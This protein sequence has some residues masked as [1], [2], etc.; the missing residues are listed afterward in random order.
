MKNSQQRRI[1]SRTIILVMFSLVWVGV[2]VLRLV[3][4]Q[5]IN[6]HEYRAIV[7]KQNQSQIEIIPKRGTIF[8]RNG[9]ILAR[10][11]PN[12]SLSFRFPHG[13]NISSQLDKI[14]KIS[15]ICDLSQGE[16]KKIQ[17]AIE[18]GEKFLYIRRKIDPEKAEKVMSL[19]LNGFNLEDENKRFYPQGKLASHVIG[20]VDVDDNGQSG[21]EYKYNSVLLGYM[22]KRVMFRDANSNYYQDEIIEQ[23]VPGK[24]L[25]LTID[26]TIQYIAEKELAKAVTTHSADWGIVIISHPGTGEIL[27]LANYPDF[28]LNHP[29]DEIEL[30][31]RIRAIHDVFDPGSTFKIVTFSAALESG[32]VSFSDVFDCSKKLQRGR[33]IFEDHEEF[34]M[35]AFPDVIIH[36]SNIGTIQIG[37][38]IGEQNLYDMIRTFGF[39]QRTGVDLPAEAPGLLNPLQKWQQNSL[40]F[41]SIGYE[42]S[43]TAIQMLQ[44]INVIANRGVATRPMIVKNIV[45]DPKKI[46]NQPYE[47]RRVI[48]E[49]IASQLIDVLQQVTEV[50]TGT[51]AHIEGY[52]IAGKTGTSQKFDQNIS[53]YSSNQHTA[54]FIGFAPVED[55]LF[56]MVIVIDNPKGLYYGG[57]V[58]APVFHEIG[59]QIFQYLRIPP[60][61]PPSK[62]LIT[63]ENRRTQEQ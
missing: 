11:M 54:S 25:N 34:G 56:S 44:T 18:Q 40:N 42:I 17:S 31:G 45:L 53:G 63:A 38:R 6:T 62:R 26:E 22:G 27:A 36:S 14:N 37:E 47:Y 23:P 32:K 35:L 19:Q 30:W 58:S 52:S 55:P 8:D 61:S 33:K 16:L 59:R 7:L 28:D 50:G 15:A 3:Q 49:E 10:S 43:V 1:K 46:Q 13:E 57:Q 51:A 21:I 24:D 5:V 48:S 41:L 9:T 60:K 39:G 4:L 2:L 12:P 20:R 29:P